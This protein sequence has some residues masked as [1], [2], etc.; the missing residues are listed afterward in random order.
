MIRVIMSQNGCAFHAPIGYRTFTI[1]VFVAAMTA[2]VVTEARS[3]PRR[4]NHKNLVG[5]G[6]GLGHQVLFACGAVQSSS[7][8]GR[9]EKAVRPS[10]FFAEAEA[11]PLPSVE[12][13]AVSSGKDLG[14][15]I[16]QDASY[17]LVSFAV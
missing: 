6:K 12:P 1:I 4:G 10:K 14:S 13:G 11:K 15:L 9:Q 8:K 3:E 16:W 2:T 7:C 17:T 5:S